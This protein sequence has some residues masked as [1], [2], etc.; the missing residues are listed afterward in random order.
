M[1]YH[2][3]TVLPPKPRRNLSVRPANLSVAT[4]AAAS[5]VPTGVVPATVI[6]KPPSR[7][8]HGHRSSTIFSVLTVGP[9]RPVP[10]TIVRT[11]IPTPA[12]LHNPT[13]VSLAPIAPPRSFVA[14]PRRPAVVAPLVKPH[15]RPV[16]A[17]FIPGVPLARGPG[18]PY[19][20]VPVRR[21]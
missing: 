16:R 9:S 19:L 12:V 20:R 10:G 13:F 15:R 2:R 4:P 11:F 17:P 6:Q 5:I 1:S 21:R 14:A 8:V 3:R 7:A 18:G